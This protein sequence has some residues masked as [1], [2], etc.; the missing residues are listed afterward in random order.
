MIHSRKNAE[1]GRLPRGPKW[2]GPAHGGDG[3][4]GVPAAPTNAA[5]DR[6][7]VPCPPP[8]QAFLLT[9]VAGQK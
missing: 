3:G 9:F 5:A 4:T 8:A 2:M 6:R 7:S 1:L